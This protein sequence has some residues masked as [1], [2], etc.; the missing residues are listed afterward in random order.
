MGNAPISIRRLPRKKNTRSGWYM[1][2][3]RTMVPR[4]FWMK[5]G[6]LLNGRESRVLG[7]VRMGKEST[8]SW[9]LPAWM[10]VSMV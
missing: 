10:T 6:M 3:M 4:E 5:W 7:L 2:Y 9:R 8:K 1:A